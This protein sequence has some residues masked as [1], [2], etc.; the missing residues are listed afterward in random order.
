VKL[1]KL[2]RWLAATTLSTVS[3]AGAAYASTVDVSNP[4]GTS[5]CFCGS[6]LNDFLEIQQQVT[7]VHGG[8]LAGID[9]YTVAGDDFDT[10]KIGVGNAFYSG[11]YAFVQTNVD[12]KS[13]GTFIDTSAA[14]IALTSGENF[15]IDVS[16]NPKTTGTL[17]GNLA[18]NGAYLNGKNLYIDVYGDGTYLQQGDSIAFVTY[19]ATPVPVPAALWLLISG[20]GALTVGYRRR[21]ARVRPQ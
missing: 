8:I 20:L 1:K 19:M 4:P 12:V 7:D 15:V 5:S 21:A 10:V 17:S 16:G 14:N 3:L 9:L 11:S 13:T 6:G 18:T 2:F